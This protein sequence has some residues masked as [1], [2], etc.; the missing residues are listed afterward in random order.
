M[1]S[2]S[3]VGSP[4]VCS[5][6][7]VSTSNSPFSTR[8]C[9]PTFDPPAVSPANPATT[10]SSA[11]AVPFELTFIGSSLGFLSTKRDPARNR[12]IDGGPARGRSRLLRHLA[13]AAGALALEVLAEEE[14]VS[15]DQ[16]DAVEARAQRGGPGALV[17][18]GADERILGAHRC[19]QV[20]Q[21]LVDPDSL[22]GARQLRGLADVDDLPV[23]IVRPEDAEQD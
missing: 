21:R 8:F 7:L 18:H 23:A 1:T 17:D 9:A 2:Q 3:G 19:H 4:P 22:V 20:A 11:F 6:P 10:T 14:A 12:E 5:Q 16:V 13:P 15:G